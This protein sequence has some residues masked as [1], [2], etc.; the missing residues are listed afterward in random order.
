VDFTLMSLVSDPHRQ[1]LYEL[2]PN[3]RE[4]IPVPLWGVRAAQ[5]LD[6]TLT[7]GKI[8]HG[9]RVTTE[10][11]VAHAFAP[12]FRQFLVEYLSDCYNPAYIA[13][14]IHRLHRYFISHDFD[15][16]MRARSTWEVFVEVTST[17]FPRVAAKA[18]Y[19]EAEFS[20]AEVASGLQ[21]LYHLFFAI[22]R[23]LPKVDVVHAAM[24]G[25]CTLVAVCSKLEHGAAY[26]LTEHGVYLREA[27]LYE[28]GQAG[29]LFLKML[30]LTFAR[31]ITELSYHHADQ[32]SPCCDY[33]QRWE[34]RMGA[35]PERIRTIRY[36]VD[37]DGFAPAGKRAGEAPAVVVWVG[38]INPLK[39][40]DTLI[41]AAALVRDQRPDIEFQLYGSATSEDEAYYQDILALRDEFNLADTVLFKGYVSKPVVAFNRGDVVVLSS[42][43]EALPFSIMEA[44][45]CAKPVVATAV[46]GV[47][48]E[49][50]ACGHVV[51]PRNPRLMADA[52]LDLMNDPERCMTLGQAAREKAMREFSLQ[53]SSR[54]HY[55]SYVRLAKLDNSDCPA[56]RSSIEVASAVPA[57]S[58]PAVH[59]DGVLLAE[60]AEEVYRRVPQPV[61]SLEITAVL[62]SMGIPDRVASQRY[63][64]AD[65]FALGNAVL[66][67]IRRKRQ[68]TQAP[69]RRRRFRAGAEIRVGVDDYAE[70]DLLPGLAGRLA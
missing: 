3:V 62:E 23:P 64:A 48:E 25:T 14:L 38:R 2:P 68:A 21:W 56:I 55:A 24:A 10:D 53:Q 44:M 60:L 16:A 39:D 43:S 4:F 13:S 49:V 69:A 46:G 58:I 45:L 54:A 42:I 37:P 30:R 61:D 57:E 50:G 51:E 66:A 7:F 40:L 29:S 18:G 59:L 28:S 1:P 19:P 26:M 65:T 27:Y 8:R 34:L 52:I 32:I 20:V 11:E 33:N 47:P 5:E 36:G 6:R 17:W 22:S 63:G 31:R 41:R 35:Q 12:L 67:W 70:R 9:R 15:L